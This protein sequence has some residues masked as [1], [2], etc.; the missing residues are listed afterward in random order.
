[1]VAQ[2]QIGQHRRLSVPGTLDNR[3]TGLYRGPHAGL[4]LPVADEILWFRPTSSGSVYENYD[5]I[6]QDKLFYTS[7]FNTSY[8]AFLGVPAQLLVALCLAV[9]LNMKVR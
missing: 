5:K 3:L 4:R 9:L 7:L 2:N 6:F 8:Y 1:M